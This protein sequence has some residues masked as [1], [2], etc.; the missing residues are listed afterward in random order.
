MDSV[1]LEAPHIN[2]RKDNLS[3]KISMLTHT[4]PLQ[5]LELVRRIVW[6]RWSLRKATSV[7]RYVK[8]AGRLRVVNGGHLVVGDRV[9]LH[10]NVAMTELAVMKGGELRIGNG[11]FINYG[12]EICAHKLI[13]I[14][15]ECRIG[16]HCIIMDNDFHDIDWR[17]RDEKPPSAEIVLEPYVWI[18]NRVTILKGVRIGFG[19]VI[20]AGSVVTKSVPPM[21]IAAGVPARVIRT[22]ET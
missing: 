18:G 1:E 2:R 15:E 16:T 6:A 10:A 17:R 22:I 7:G 19:S 13:H 14:G 5:T 20:A 9:L 3:S 11:A 12:A 4:S 21:S 8:L